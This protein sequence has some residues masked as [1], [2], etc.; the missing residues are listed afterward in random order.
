MC[1]G[2]QHVNRS[3]SSVLRATDIERIKHVFFTDTGGFLL[4]RGDLAES[5]INEKM[6]GAT[7]PIT[8]EQL[9]YLVDQSYAKIPDIKKDSI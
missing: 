5:F 4:A 2:S 9:F 7:F 6:N 1:K 8:A 3:K